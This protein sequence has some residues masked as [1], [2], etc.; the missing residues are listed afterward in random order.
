M[1]PSFSASKCLDDKD[2]TIEEREKRRGF[3]KSK[4]SISTT[5]TRSLYLNED[6]YSPRKL[7]FLGRRLS[8]WYPVCFRLT[9]TLSIPWE[10][11][12]WGL[13]RWF[14]LLFLGDNSPKI[15]LTQ[16]PDWA[17]V[18]IS[19]RWSERAGHDRSVDTRLIPDD[20]H[21]RCLIDEPAS[22]T[23]AHQ[24]DSGGWALRSRVVC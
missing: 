11:P 8:S 10:G 23:L 13:A 16:T 18:D 21:H 6:N 3:L 4:V 1:A 24:W 19:R 2:Q 9:F 14:I 12:F 17:L 15:A 5:F 20:V 7:A 22:A